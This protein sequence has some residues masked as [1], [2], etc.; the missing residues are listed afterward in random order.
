MVHIHLYKSAAAKCCN[1]DVKRRQPERETKLTE[2]ER[3][4]VSK[5]RKENV[6]RKNIIED[7]IKFFS[8]S[9]LSFYTRGADLESSPRVASRTVR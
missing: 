9:E 2:R 5:A 4:F 6:V 8:Q 1:R 3:D 7:G